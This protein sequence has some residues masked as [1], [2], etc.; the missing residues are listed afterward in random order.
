[1]QNILHLM[2]EQNEHFVSQISVPYSGLRKEA[3]FNLKRSTKKC[4]KSIFD[5]GADESKTLN[6]LNH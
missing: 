2:N 4:N 6:N 3:V 5:C 1:M